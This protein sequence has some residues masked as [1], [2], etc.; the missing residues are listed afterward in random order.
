M[1]RTDKKEAY[2]QFLMQIEEAMRVSR[3]ERVRAVRKISGAQ[4]R[5]ARF[6]TEPLLL[7]CSPVCSP[8]D[9]LSYG[10]A[11]GCRVAVTGRIR[12][13]MSTCVAIE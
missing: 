6:N 4:S 9:H 8:H 13:S 12:R 2:S 7:V 5:N 1:R 3:L 10:S 11:Y